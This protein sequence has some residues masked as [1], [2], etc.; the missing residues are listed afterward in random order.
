MVDWTDT[1]SVFLKEKR[2]GVRTWKRRKWKEQRR[3]RSE[4]ENKQ[5]VCF[6]SWPA[7]TEHFKKILTNT[8]NNLLT[9]HI[10][11]SVFNFKKSWKSKTLNMK[12]KSVQIL[13]TFDHKHTQKHSV[14]HRLTAFQQKLQQT[15][16]INKTGQIFLPGC[17]FSAVT[18]SSNM[19]AR[20]DFPAPFF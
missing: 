11:C 3:K 1:F 12:A 5:L 9:D 16:G 15:A 13:L 17:N 10:F 14:L 7:P 6:Q 2:K 20:S 18:F 19:A 8:W 4:E